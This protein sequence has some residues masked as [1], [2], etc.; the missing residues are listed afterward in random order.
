MTGES[1]G[2]IDLADHADADGLPEMSSAVANGDLVF[3][4]L[5]RLDRDN[6]WVADPEG[7][8]AVVDPATLTMVRSLAVGPNPLLVPHPDGGAVAACDDGLW[9]VHADS[10]SGPVVPGGLDGALGALTFADDGT[11]YALHRPCADCAG[12]RLICLDAWDGPLL[13]ETEPVGAFLSDLAVVDDTLWIAARRGWEDPS[14]AG[15]FLAMPRETC[16]PLPAPEAWHRGTYAPF[17]LA[18]RTLP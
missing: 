17:D 4:A 14:V 6:G 18:V 8:V 12:H 5:Q 10:V 1:L 9:R 2:T 11:A 7:R 13:G 3:V 15:G 16:G